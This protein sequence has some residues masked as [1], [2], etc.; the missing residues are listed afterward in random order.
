MTGLLLLEIVTAVLVCRP[1]AAALLAV[2]VIN[3]ALPPTGAVNKP[4]EE[5]VPALAAHRTEVLLPSD[6][7]ALN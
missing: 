4:V 1:L 6:T 2:I 7:A 3:F 5:I